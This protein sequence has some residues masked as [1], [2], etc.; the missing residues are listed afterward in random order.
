MTTNSKYFMHMQFYLVIIYRH[1]L[2]ASVNITYTAFNTKTTESEIIYHYINTNNRH[3]RS[4][5]P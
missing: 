3:S 2:T 5:T 4:Q 1:E